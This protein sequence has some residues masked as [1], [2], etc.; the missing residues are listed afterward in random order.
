MVGPQM[1]RCLLIM[2]SF[3]HKLSLAVLTPE[4]EELFC[5]LGA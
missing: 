5:E 3:V 4:K 2:T 1:K